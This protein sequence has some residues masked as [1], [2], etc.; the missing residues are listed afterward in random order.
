MKFTDRR[1]EVGDNFDALYFE[2]IIEVNAS[3]DT[4]KSM[5]LEPI[6]DDLTANMFVL[7]DIIRSTY[8]KLITPTHT[9]IHST[10]STKLL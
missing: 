4:E 2:T 7:A 6:L 9:P 10:R 1:S 3:Q 8:I 5:Y